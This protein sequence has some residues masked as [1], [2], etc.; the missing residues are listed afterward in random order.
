M[1]SNKLNLK[2]EKAL[3]FLFRSL[4]AL[5]AF[6]VPVAIIATRY[7][8]ITKFNGYKLTAVG[9][10]LIVMV[11]WRFKTQLMTWINNWE[12]SI[13]KYILVGF[14]RVYI[15]ILILII[16]LL[17]QKGLEDLIFCI[18]WVCICEFLAYL[19]FYPLEQKYD[20]RVKRIIRG[21][22]RKEDYKEVI[23]ELRGGN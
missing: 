23:E 9:I 22:E 8:L 20:Y 12:Y 7:Q 6:L 3:R 4:F 14:S 16:L 15:Y 10:L 1:A 13:M 2:R 5:S 21:I 19:V 17:A 11:V 18:E